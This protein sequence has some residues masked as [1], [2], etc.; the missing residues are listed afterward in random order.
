VKYKSH[1]DGG[2][3]G[4]NRRWEV[5]MYVVLYVRKK[6]LSPSILYEYGI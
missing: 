4:R 5:R 2:S 6:Q 1:G 3:N